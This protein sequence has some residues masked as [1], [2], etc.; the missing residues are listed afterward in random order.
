MREY[1]HME[2]RGIRAVVLTRS[3]KHKKYC[4]AGLD[5]RTGK[6]VRFIS[7]DEKS[8]GALSKENIRFLNGEYC[9]PLDI[10]EVA[11]KCFAPSRYQPENCL[12]D[13]RYRWRKVGECT[14]ERVLRFH[15]AEVWPCLYRNLLPYVE[16][17]DMSDEGPS[18]TL[19]RVSELCVYK[20]HRARTK[21]RFEYNAQ[22]YQDISVT[23]PAYYDKN[24]TTI[25]K[26]YLVVSLPSDPFPE[27][28]YY[29]FI[30]QIFP[31]Y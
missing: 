13:E 11:V 21:A 8:C 12:I 10:V 6:W 7:D 18:L 5:I 9:K 23:D 20:N 16:E 2:I 25:G 24:D 31:A 15:P 4:V 14:L 1:D 28:R 19:I 3:S 30:A 22:L 26:A 27:N 17:E 29:K